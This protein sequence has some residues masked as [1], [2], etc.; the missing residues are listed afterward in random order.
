MQTLPNLS[1]LSSC[2][3]GFKKR[4]KV[5]LPERWV[6]LGNSDRFNEAA[7]ISG[8]FGRFGFIPQSDLHPAAT[9]AIRIRRPH[10]WEKS[11]GNVMI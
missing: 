11:F 3:T 4:E 10:L 5:S 8:Y 1:C 7:M 6:T 9:T 2:S